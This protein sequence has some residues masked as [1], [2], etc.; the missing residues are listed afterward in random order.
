MTAI[1]T[2]QFISQLIKDTKESLSGNVYI[3]LGRSLTWNNVAE[4]DPETPFA[5]TNDFEY[6]REARSA[7]QHVKIATGISAAITRQDW[8]ADT[9]YS[10]Y[11][12]APWTS[13]PFDA[14][15]IPYVMNSNYEIFL[16]VQ[17]GVDASGNVIPSTVE[18]LKANLPAPL[19]NPVLAGENVL[20]TLDVDGSPG[21]TW[22]YLFTLSQVAVN[23]FLTSNFIP[24]TT[25]TADP[26]DQLVQ[27]E[28][29]QIQ[30]ISQPGQILNIKVID[31]GAGY[32]NDVSSSVLGNAVTPNLAT[33][34]T[35][36]IGGVI[37][38]IEVPVTG[39]G[40]DYASV[41]IN[42]G[43]NNPTEDA[44][45]RPVIGPNLGIEADP[46]V[47]LKANSIIVTTDF[48]NDEFDTLLTENDFRQILLL[49]SPTVYDGST[50]FLQSTGK[51][52]RALICT[53]APPVGTVDEDLVMTGQTSQAQG[54]VDYFE[55]STNLYYHQTPTTG[56][57]TFLRGEPV[58]I[59]G[60]GGAVVTLTGA[61]SSTIAANQVDPAL[62]IF[63]GELL[64]IDNIA[65]ISRDPNQTED[66]KIVITF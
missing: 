26:L 50:A 27:T 15:A 63:S 29:W 60:S 61:A 12:D 62:D 3:G 57:G 38:S 42:P 39:F 5:P 33:T 54:I 59:A 1:V 41:K 4:L 17:Q 66:I 16:C 30:Q 55:N 34:I 37:A 22:R 6:A 19:S 53:G 36:N 52:N 46:I 58:E 7:C 48:E 21:Y 8:V 31:G 43:S 65:P 25:F 35:N 51:A 18:P 13:I 2:E 23:R 11:D 64:Y 56:Y 40:Y 9:K 20:V 32:A 14:E 10:A 47:T 49:K 44:T 24:V 45:V 28:Q